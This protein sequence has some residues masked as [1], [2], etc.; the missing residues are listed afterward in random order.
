MIQKLYAVVSRL[1]GLCGGIAALMMV[2]LIL[3][4]VYEVFARYAFNSPTTWAFEIGYMAM[5]A[6]FLLATSYALRDEQHVRV[7]V[8]VMNVRPRARALIDGIAYLVLF[9][10]IL[11]WL[12]W[13][14]AVFTHEAY[15][16]GER[17][18]E[19]A[20]NPIIWPFYAVWAFSFAAFTLQGI[21]E[22]FR[23]F[24]FVI[25]GRPMEKSNG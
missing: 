7:D 24:Y 21:A 12:T 19:S 9:I 1:S 18:G 2:P 17:S 8:F 16:W 13:E 20:W 10:P 3:G 25:T 4:S 11:P 15:V 22:M 14:L 6:C 5:G 23:N